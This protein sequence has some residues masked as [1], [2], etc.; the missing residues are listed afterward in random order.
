V[1]CLVDLLATSAGIVGGKLP[2]Q[3]GEDSYN[4]LPVLLGNKIDQ[5]I[6]EATIHHSGGG[7]FAIRKG[8]W[9]LIEESRG[10]GYN[11]GPEKGSPGQLYNLHDDPGEQTN[12]WEIQSEKVKELLNLLEKYKKQGY[13]RPVK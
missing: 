8:D 7:V 1:V 9:K 11:S 10:A 2:D 12:L 3:Y 4:M 5:P 6:R 13:S